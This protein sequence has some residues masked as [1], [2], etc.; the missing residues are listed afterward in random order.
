MKT[1]NL[2]LMKIYDIA[3]IGAGPAGCMAAIQG[4]K[5]GKNIILIERNNR[6]GRKLL[7][8][9]NGRCNITNTS[10]LNVFLEKF[11]RKGLFYRDAFT[12]FSNK[13]LIYFFKNHG[14]DVK[15]LED[16][17]VFPVT[18]KSESVVNILERVLTENKVKLC[19]NY[20]IKHLQKQSN[21]FKLSSNNGHDIKAYNV[22]IA[23]GGE[24]YK[25]TG[26]KGDGLKIA[27]SLG[28]KIEKQ[29]PGAV[30]L[31]VREK[32]VYDLKGVTLGNVELK[33]RYGN[34]ILS[35]GCGNL[36]LT[37]F[38]ISGPLILDKSN[39]IIEIMQ[40]YGELKLL[41]DFKPDINENDLETIFINDFKNY[42]KRS[43]K[44]YLRVHLTDS[45]INHVLKFI[46]IDLDKKLNQITKNERLT[47][48]QALKAFPLTITGHLPLDKAMVTCGGVALKEINPKTM[49]SKL[50]KNLFF[51]GE[52]IAGCG[53]TGGYN[54]QQAFSTGYLAGI[55]AS[56]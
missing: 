20:R 53:Q 17:K 50:I 49:E 39:F 15:E 36:L 56:K 42:G 14:L 41:I 43:L 10:T 4:A 32:W 54:L 44:N 37:H 33:V 55:N 24:S 2:I 6:I 48:I 28:H 23:T 13:D 21:I 22:I 16:G 47:L 27:N 46:N 35:L 38:G 40:N 52:M 25:N 8:T 1:H 26:S 45:L 34:K 5:T 30:P 3:I 31:K 7:L 12:L 19:Y 11:G 29:T 18:E 51:A 9:A